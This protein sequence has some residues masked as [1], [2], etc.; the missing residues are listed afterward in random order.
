MAR[1]GLRIGCSCWH[2]NPISVRNYFFL[3]VHVD[4]IKVK[5]CKYYDSINLI[6]IFS[7]QSRNTKVYTVVATSVINSAYKTLCTGR[8]HICYKVFF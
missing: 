1:S 4:A 5:L 3:E 2:T 7:I 8:V 6:Q